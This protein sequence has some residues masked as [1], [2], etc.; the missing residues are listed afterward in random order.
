MDGN[1]AAYIGD[2]IYGGVFIRY[3]WFH[4]EYP[5]KD[6]QQLI[7]DAFISRLHMGFH[8][9]KQESFIDAS[10]YTYPLNHLN[11]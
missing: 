6:L 1:S 11:I 9:D 8:Y 4:K 2:K 7:I 10:H 5:A 3:H